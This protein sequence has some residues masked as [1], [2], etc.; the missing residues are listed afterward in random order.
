MSYFRYGV[1]HTQSGSNAKVELVFYSHGVLGAC[2]VGA[3]VEVGILDIEVC[4]GRLAYKVTELR[5]CLE[6]E[7]YAFALTSPRQVG[8]DGHLNV[9]HV[10]LIGFCHTRHGVYHRLV[11]GCTYALLPSYACIVHFGRN[12]AYR[13]EVLLAGVAHRQSGC[14]SGV[15]VER[16]LRRKPYAAHYI[17]GI[18]ANG[19]VVAVF[20]YLGVYGGRCRQQH[21]EQGNGFKS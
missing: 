14:H 1:F 10:T 12:R 21:C 13:L 5:A 11:V 15:S 18:E 7:L 3:V 17:S 19:Q 9:V 6:E 4:L 16:N 8:E 2:L 20:A